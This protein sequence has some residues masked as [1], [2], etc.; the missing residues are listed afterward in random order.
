[1]KRHERR[2]NGTD[3]LYP[4]IP[5]YFQAIR[6]T[7]AETSGIRTIPFLLSNIF[8]AIPVGAAVSKIGY[9]T[10]FIW[11]GSAIFPVGAGLLYLLKVNST[12]AQWIGY[13]IL[14]GASS[15]ACIQLPFIA[16]QCV[17]NSKDMPV[18][19]AIAV[20]FNTM[21]G[22]IGVSIAENIF[23]N[24]LKR[25]ISKDAKGV[26]AEAIIAAGATGFRDL[27]PAGQLAAVLKAYN[28]AVTDVF[29]IAVA[30]GGLAFLSSFLFE[31]KSVRGKSLMAGGAA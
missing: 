3:A 15:G 1:M 14:A 10:P 20:F 30:A 25:E 26:D 5:I 22:A 23:S 2:Q 4:D 16:V 27:V 13:Q 31:M 21:G 28:T 24:G 19:N 12:T 17:L 29:T 7:D 18:G 6:D 9:Y 8:A 11:V